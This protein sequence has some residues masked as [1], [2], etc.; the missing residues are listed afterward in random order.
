M[1][2]SFAQCREEI[3]GTGWADDLHR[4]SLSAAEAKFG[5]GGAKADEGARL[6]ALDL[7]EKDRP[8]LAHQIV[9]IERSPDGERIA[10]CGQRFSASSHPRGWWST[11]G[12]RLPLQDH[13]IHCQA[14]A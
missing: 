13:A 11:E 9:L 5:D 10:A 4:A 8:V 6:W 14:G 3:T 2:R 7:D 1:T 12:G